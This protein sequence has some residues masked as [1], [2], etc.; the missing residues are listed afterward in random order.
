VLNRLVLGACLLINSPVLQADDFPVKPIRMIV[1]YP[2]GGGTDIVTRTVA[3]RL[4]ENLGKPVVVE[5]R[6]GAGM[7]AACE[8]VAKAPP[9]GYTLGVVDSGFCIN[10]SL[11]SKLPY[12]SVNDFAPVVLMTRLQN[13]LV[14]SLSFPPNTIKELIALAKEKPGQ[15]NFATSGVGGFSH[16]PSRSL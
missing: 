13:M 1:P 12:D 9:D 14:A 3:E 4:T 15:I 8:I 16:S 7:I 5:N 6:P 11:R 2:P 10:L